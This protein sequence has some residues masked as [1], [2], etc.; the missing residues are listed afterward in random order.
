VPEAAVANLAEMERQAL[1]DLIA[2]GAAVATSTTDS[3]I[4]PI[5][6]REAEGAL[7]AALPAHLGA[8]ALGVGDGELRSAYALEPEWELVVRHVVR[9][10]ESARSPAAID[11]ARAIAEEV[12]ALAAAGADFATLAAEYSEEPGAARRGGLLEPGRR[13]SWVEP[14]WEAASRLAPGEVSAVVPTEYGFHVLRLDDRRPV[15]F[16]EADRTALLRRVVA[17]AEASAA[18]ER[19]ASTEGGILLD[20]PAVAEVH[21]LLQSGA[22][23]PDSL[24][25]AT[26]ATGGSYRGSDLAAG[27]A[28][29][30]PDER[31]ALE[32]ADVQALA[33]WVESDA[34]SSIWAEHARA[35]GIRDDAASATTA[36]LQWQ[37]R[38]LGWASVFGFR[39][40]LEEGEILDL[41]VRGTLSGAAQARAARAELRSLRFLLR[42]AYPLVDLEP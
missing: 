25:L 20:P 6:R 12:A 31:M 11:S 16:E 39:P 37:G 33:G 10:T 3:L 32:R 36:R 28:T 22:A 19:W 24:V 1:A 17:P 38:V 41:A 8:A 15:P 18:M 42:S 34:R 40:G 35:I 13:G 29:I 2:F 4:E 9:L 27:W 14:F 23:L 5:V 30:P 26:G 21:A 7:V